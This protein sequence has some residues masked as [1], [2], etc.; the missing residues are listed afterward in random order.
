MG[1]QH[2]RVYARLRHAMRG[3]DGGER[4]PNQPEVLITQRTNVSGNVLNGPGR[5]ENAA[6]NCGFLCPFKPRGPYLLFRPHAM[7]AFVDSRADLENALRRP[8]A[9][10]EQNDHASLLRKLDRGSLARVG[11]AAHGLVDLD[12]RLG[13]ADWLDDFGEN[14]GVAGDLPHQRNGPAVFAGQTVVRALDH[15]TAASVLIS[16]LFGDAAVVVVFCADDRDVEPLFGE[17]LDHA[18]KF[19]DERADQIV[20]QVDAT[21]GKAFFRLPVQSMKPEHETIALA[22]L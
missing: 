10:I 4:E 19:F 17:P 14:F 12:W 16:N 18:I 20:E 11:V 8:A 6:D 21:R 7:H 2:K 5:H 22:Q 15:V 13:A 9:V 3:D 1:P